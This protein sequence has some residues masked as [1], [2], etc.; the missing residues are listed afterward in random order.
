MVNKQSYCDLSWLARK[1]SESTMTVNHNPFKCATTHYTNNSRL[2]AIVW[3]GQEWNYRISDSLVLEI[4]FRTIAISQYVVYSSTRHFIMCTAAH[5]FIPSLNWGTAAPLLVHSS[6]KRFNKYS[7]KYANRYSNKYVTIYALKV[8]QQ[9][10]LVVIQYII[11]SSTWYLIH[12]YV[13]ILVLYM[14]PD[15]TKN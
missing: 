7:S 8:V 5:M 11:Y 4:K 6:N 1:W 12:V 9:H 2:S 13:S 14:I 10:I 3:V 15:P